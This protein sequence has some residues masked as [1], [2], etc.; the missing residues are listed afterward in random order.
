MLGGLLP[1]FFIFN[2]VRNRIPITFSPSGR[3]SG[4]CGGGLFGDCST[5]PL[6]LKSYH[7][8]LY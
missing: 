4:Q 7:F 8:L 6:F 1:L 5:I 2:D 3:D